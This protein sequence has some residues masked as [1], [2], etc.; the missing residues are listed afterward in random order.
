MSNEYNLDLMLKA[1]KKYGT[2][3]K[4]SFF[5]IKEIYK[6]CKNED[7]KKER[8][9]GYRIELKLDKNKITNNHLYSQ[10]LISTKI[11]NKKET[12]NTILKQIPKLSFMAFSEKLKNECITI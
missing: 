9:L 8:M 10:P 11:Q 4:K 6:N 1:L 2:H 3:D 12:F 7:N 5:S